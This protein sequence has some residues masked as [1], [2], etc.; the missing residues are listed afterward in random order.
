[1]DPEIKQQL[2]E[3]HALVRDNHNLLRAVRRHQ[4][5]EM[6]GKY[7][8][9]IIIIASSVYWVVTYLEPLAAKFSTSTGM[10]PSGPFGLPTSADLQKLINSYKVGQ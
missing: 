1:M 3:I 4:I 10:S 7:V 9:W 8:F 2:T 6:V 5:F